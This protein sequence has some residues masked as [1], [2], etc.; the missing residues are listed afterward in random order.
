V[1]SDYGIIIASVKL[2]L[3]KLPT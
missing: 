2:T 1:F 3:F